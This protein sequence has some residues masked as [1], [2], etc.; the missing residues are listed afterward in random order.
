MDIAEALSKPGFP[1]RAHQHMV[2]PKG[3]SGKDYSVCSIGES[4][5]YKDIQAET[6]L[7]DCGS[8]MV[9]MR[10]GKGRK[11]RAR[12]EDSDISGDL[13][14]VNFDQ[15]KKKFG[16]VQEVHRIPVIYTHGSLQASRWVVVKPSP[17]S[18]RTRTKVK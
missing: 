17:I 14:K 12:K 7:K 9:M 4:L 2:T 3:G 18:W 15:R 16:E 13:S 10:N 5:E 6:K 11:K 1:D 8:V